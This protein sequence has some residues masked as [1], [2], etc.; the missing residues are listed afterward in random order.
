MKYKLK[1]NQDFRLR[2]N[3]WDRIEQSPPLQDAYNNL[4]NLIEQAAITVEN[5]KDSDKTKWIRCIVLKDD[6]PLFELT[7][8]TDLKKT[9]K[10]TWSTDINTCNEEE[11]EYYITN[12]VNMSPNEFIH[13]LQTDEY[14]HEEGNQSNI[15]LV[16]PVGPQEES[17]AEQ[18]ESGAE[19][20]KP[21]PVNSTVPPPKPIDDKNLTIPWDELTLVQQKSIADLLFLKKNKINYLRISKIT[22]KIT[23]PKKVG[24]STVLTIT[25]AV[26]EIKYIIQNLALHRW[27]IRAENNELTTFYP[28]PT[29]EIIAEDAQVLYHET[30]DYWNNE[31]YDLAVAHKMLISPTINPKPLSFK[32]RIKTALNLKHNVKLEG[33]AGSGKSTLAKTMAHELNLDFYKMTLT[34]QTTEKNLI[35]YYNPILGKEISSPIVEAYTHGGLLF[36]DEMDAGDPNTLIIVNSVCDRELAHHT[37]GK[38]IPC[39]KDFRLISAIN[40]A[41]ELHHYVGKNKLDRSTNSRYKNFKMTKWEHRFDRNILDIYDKV[42]DLALQL[43]KESHWCDLIV[44]DRFVLDIPILGIKASL[45]DLTEE[46]NLTSSQVKTLIDVFNQV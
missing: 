17:G 1:R 39:H 18:E 6:T 45:E 41:D 25:T 12:S 36:I 44:L 38:I 10:I 15:L 29:N 35:G 7:E 13:K 23:Q 43:G 22:G 4:A 32:E 37:T 19:G 9:D 16:P 2:L 20:Y 24:K 31:E 21:Y 8:S 3:N 30:W 26:T 40:L 5:L 27:S 28:L 34:R 33:Q 11:Y 42:N 14:L 46:L